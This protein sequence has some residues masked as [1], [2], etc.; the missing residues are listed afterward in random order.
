MINLF[1]R[2]IMVAPILDEAARERTVYLPAGIW[3]DYWTEKIY[4][5]PR[6]VKFPA[7]LD[8]LPLFIRQGAIIPMGPNVQFSGQRP[9]D[10]LT[11][12]IYRGADRW[13][14]LYEDDGES[15]ACESG[16]Y[17]ETAFEVTTPAGELR[18][19]IGAVQG[20]F[21]GHRPERTVVLN[22][23]QQDTV[24][25]VSC[26]AAAMAQASTSQ[27]LEQAPAGWWWNAAA[28]ILTVKLQQTGA[29]LMLRV[30]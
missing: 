16:E 22:I 12:E 21:R 7:P 6:F 25:E 3:I 13:F 4:A 9:L 15:T 26:D 28:A 24:R 20:G 30:S 14:T 2:E 1:G 23:H 5:G 8:T 27:S 10:P 11:M 18:C 29:A 19:S 17:A